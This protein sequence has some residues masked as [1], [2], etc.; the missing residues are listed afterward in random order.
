M[1]L[2]QPQAHYLVTAVQPAEQAAKA[3]GN[4]K[5]VVAVHGKSAVKKTRSMKNSGKKQ[6]NH[7]YIPSIVEKCCS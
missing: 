3:A 4:S 7:S 2:H 6:R 5:W 1:A